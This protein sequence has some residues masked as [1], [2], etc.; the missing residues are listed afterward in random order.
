MSEVKARYSAVAGGASLLSK[1]RALKS[2]DFPEFVRGS[3]S[4]I[5]SED[6]RRFIDWEAGLLSMLL[7]HA[8]QTVDG[9]SVRAI[10]QG[11]TSLPLGHALEREVAAQLL[12]I[13]GCEDWQVRWCVTG[14]AANSAAVRVARAITGHETVI[15]IGYHGIDDWALAH[16]PP[17][18]GVPKG[19]KWMTLP[20]RFN[21]LAA[22]DDHFNV[23]NGCIAAIVVEPVTTD[24]P[25]PGYLAA[26]RDYCDRR[27]KG[28]ALIFDEAITA[29]R[30][31][32]FTAGKHF[33]VTPDIWVTSK[34][35]ANGLPLSAVVGQRD[36][37]RAF[38]LDFQPSYA[39]SGSGPTYVSGTY[40]IPGVSL[41]ACRATLDVWNTRQV[42]KYLHDLGSLLH[43]RLREAIIYHGMAEH[44]T[45]KGP[46]YRLA[47][48]YS[49]LAVKTFVLRQ[50]L[51]RGHVLAASGMNLM[52]SHTQAE[53]MDAA[54][55][56]WSTL[57]E[58]K[59]AM[60]GGTVAEKAGRPVVQVYRQS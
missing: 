38:D 17:A 15:S 45:V 54:K 52:A 5:Y 49:D 60:A 12:V 26:L 40:H 47:L 48:D 51:A 10:S 20:A 57:N 18:W 43:V 7:G 29:G 19:V 32:E 13:S 31:P 41:A 23:T 8:H 14:T 44:V 9:A 55:A 46:P 35:L 16:T 24:D 56:F 11:I 34:C 58:L 30:Y 53:V 28:T 2:E 4:S 25:A 42:G 3:G 37:M 36:W 27:G 22:L 33:G 39:K 21:D 1:S 50:M 6:G 59:T